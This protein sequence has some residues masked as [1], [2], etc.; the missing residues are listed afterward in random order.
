M[1][2]T[3]HM[4]HAPLKFSRNSLSTAR[5]DKGPVS[6]LRALMPTTLCLTREQTG[7]RACHCASWSLGQCFYIIF[8]SE[9]FRLA[10]MKV[11][12]ETILGSS[13][14][15]IICPSDVQAFQTHWKC[16]RL[17]NC[18]WIKEAKYLKIA[19]R[20]LE[21]HLNIK[22]N[23]IRRSDDELHCEL[24]GRALRL[25]FSARHRLEIPQ[26]A[27]LKVSLTM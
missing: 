27:Y 26:Y 1:A 14:L 22:T 18:P 2:C 10:Q 23:T 20:N 8:S 16:P 24:M 11:P 17:C 5:L 15:E 25:V 12:A 13:V 3:Y 19:P 21:M 9:I 6:R 7:P 4:D